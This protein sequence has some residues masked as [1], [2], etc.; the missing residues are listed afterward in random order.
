MR[1]SPCRLSL[2]VEPT[3]LRV[4]GDRVEL[5]FL[6]ECLLRDA[7]HGGQDGRLLLSAACEEGFARVSFTDTRR[8]F[9]Q[10]ELNQFFSPRREQLRMD[11]G[12]HL[13]GVEHLLCKQ[14]IRDHDEHA[15]R[16]G[17]RINAVPCPEG[18]FTVYFTL[19]LKTV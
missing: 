3:S 1:K 17:C 18:G 4:T 5:R 16:R 2:E 7:A 10:E 12:G 6:L 9:S 14:V 13:R 8:C 19:P 11:E 15:G